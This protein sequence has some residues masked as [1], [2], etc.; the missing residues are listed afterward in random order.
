M[1]EFLVCLFQAQTITNTH[2]A[3][4]WEKSS[5][6]YIKAFVALYANLNFMLCISDSA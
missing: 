6:N 3:A 1:L 5:N 4:L 2:K